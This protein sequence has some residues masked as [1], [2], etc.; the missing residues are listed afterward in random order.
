MKHSLYI[1]YLCF[2]SAP[3]DVQA[4]DV[5]GFFEALE[6]EQAQADMAKMLSKKKP[7]PIAPDGN[8]SHTLKNKIY[9][10]FR[11]FHS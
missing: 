1:A 5:L 2:F 6:Q 7:P 8:I 9:F 11:S 3:A 10:Y 4:T